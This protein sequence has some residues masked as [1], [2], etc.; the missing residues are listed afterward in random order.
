MGT[1]AG[2]SVDRDALAVIDAAGRF[3]ILDL[4]DEELAEVDTIT[5]ALALHAAKPPDDP[6]VYRF[7]AVITKQG[8][9]A[10]GQITLTMTVPWEHHDEVFRALDTMPFTAMVKMTEIT[11]VTEGD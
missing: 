7:Y 10:T 6:D 4:T 2:P 3:G 8:T 9:T 11:G 5:D 1:G